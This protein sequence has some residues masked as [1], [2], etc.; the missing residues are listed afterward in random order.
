MK[1]NI[2]IIL[3]F[4]VL[5]FTACETDLKDLNTD[6]GRLADVEL[7][8]MLPDAIVQSMHNEGSN[9]NRIAGVVTQQFKG[10][11]AQQIQYSDYVLGEDAVNNYWNLGLYTGAL[12]SCQVIIDKANDEGASYYGGVAKILMANQYGIAT[13][14]FGDIP[15]SEALKG[16]EIQ[17]PAY[18]SQESVYAG[19]QALLDSGI[20][21]LGSAEGYVGGDLIFDGD[22]AKWIATAKAFKARYLMHTQKRD[23]GAA[24][25]ALSELSGAFTSIADQPNF[26]FE[27][28]ETANWALAKFGI[29]RPSTLGIDPFF[30]N[31]MNGDPRQEH[32]MID[33]GGA[34]WDF[35]EAGNSKLVWA[36]S[37]A[38]IPLISIVEVKFLEAEALARTGAS[39]D[40]VEAALADAITAS[41]TQVGV[42]PDSIGTYITDN[43]SIDGDA[44]TA[45]ITEAYKAYFGFAFHETWANYRRTGVPALVPS[46]IGTNGFNPSGVVPRRLLYVES[47]TATNSANVDAAR[48]RQGGGLLDQPVWAFE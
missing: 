48:A 20:A 12:R 41:M 30:T 21:D 11:D 36:K 19:V 40:D 4:V 16:L 8:L 28:A 46:S 1:L 2:Y 23:G 25:A 42:S 17:Q 31:L 22:A 9:H 7:R 14:M 44:I 34:V 38:T 37:D 18:D 32:Y 45:I 39:D 29:E 24:A 13:S 5:G 47:E 35:F 27:T 6:P 33:L 26:T 15:F 43:S 3:A 10:L